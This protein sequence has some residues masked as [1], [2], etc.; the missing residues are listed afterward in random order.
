[1]AEYTVVNEETGQEITFD[2]HLD[3]P[4]TDA[5]MEEIFAQATPPSTEPR[6]PSEADP[7]VELAT[8]G[9][10]TEQRGLAEGGKRFLTGMGQM[11]LAGEEKL[12][13]VT[14]EEYAD[15]TFEE[16]K[17]RS[18]VEQEGWY[19]DSATAK[20]SVFMGEMLPWF[21][22]KSTATKPTGRAFEAGALGGLGGAAQFTTEEDDRLFN[23]LLG[24]N[25]G[26]AAQSM[27][28]LRPRQMYMRRKIHEMESDPAY[29]E[30]VRRSLELGDEGGVLTLAELSEHPWFIQLQRTAMTGKQAPAWK[31]HRIQSLEQTDKALKNNLRALHGSQE[32]L[33]QQTAGRVIRKS[34]KSH[35]DAIYK[36]A[37]D[38]FSFAMRQVDEAVGGKPFVD[39]DNVIRELNEVIA[40]WSQSGSKAKIS[41][42]KD[43]E[44]F[45]DSLQKAKTSPEGTV[46]GSQPR[47]LSA[48]ETIDKFKRWGKAS[49]G[50]GRVVF[51][52]DEGSTL[53]AEVA[54]R[55][56][57]AFMDGMD[58]QTTIMNQNM[59][60]QGMEKFVAARSRYKDAMGYANEVGNSTLGKMVQK[61]YDKTGS[62]P[63]EAFHSVLGKLKPEE[64]QTTL[65]IMNDVNPGSVNML[66]KRIIMDALDNAKVSGKRGEMDWEYDPSQLVKLLKQEGSGARGQAWM[67]VG[68]TMPKEKEIRLL[69]KKMRKLA[70]YEPSGTAMVGAEQQGQRIAGLAGD[71]AT[72]SA[73][74][75]V[76]AATASFRPMW[77]NSKFVTEVLTNPEA[78][79]AVMTL[80]YA[81]SKF[82]KAADFAKKGGGGQKMAQSIMILTGLMSETDLQGF[83]D[84]LEAV[85]KNPMMFSNQRPTDVLRVAPEKFKS[86]EVA[87]RYR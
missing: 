80:D 43:L 64:L 59:T 9:W 52:G 25:I 30:T 6:V 16:A 26:V 32:E 56:Y 67:S 82:I 31:K 73:P 3:T 84:R 39:T 81:A 34:Y 86:G 57:K 37:N 68:Q 83:N 74:N 49:R 79:Q 51:H 7:R 58:A 53:D 60:R 28:E 44:V 77:A 36:A 15:F 69:L 71:V 20:F 63:D 10:T 18:Q 8:G 42:I 24:M 21:I 27:L 66:R 11:I 50:Q 75:A 78:R 46:I 87:P 65:S 40:E 48:K 12:G 1:M 54:P 76:F 38:E 17:R 72:G 23:T 33:T 19:R 29:A 61:A 55:I 14:P 5:D 2:W 47:L 85:Q 35:T 13:T 70:Q 62:T 41:K 4:P 45:R 22:F